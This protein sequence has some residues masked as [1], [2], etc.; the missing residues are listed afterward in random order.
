M[1][2]G[3]RRYLKAIS[4]LVRLASM[5]R[6]LVQSHGS[7]HVEGMANH[8]I[9][10]WRLHEIHACFQLCLFAIASSIAESETSWFDLL[11]IIDQGI[12]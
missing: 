7:R 11:A 12:F 5:P 3:Y 2:Y 10:S 4:I 1:D 6:W 9:I 8:S